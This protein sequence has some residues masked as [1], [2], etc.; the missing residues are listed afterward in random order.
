MGLIL[1]SNNSLAQK[2]DLKWTK[3]PKATKSKEVTQRCEAQKHN[4]SKAQLSVVRGVYTQLCWS[5]ASSPSPAP[6]A[7]PQHLRHH[8]QLLRHSTSG[9]TSDNLCNDFYRSCQTAP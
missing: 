1:K 8:L 9:S 4:K 5:S 6:T 3:R 2:V 7:R